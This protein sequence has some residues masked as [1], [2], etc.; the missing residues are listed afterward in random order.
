MKNTIAANI[1]ELH[2]RIAAACEEFD[3]DADDITAVAITKNHPAAVIRTAV[4]SGLVEIGES[5]VLEAK[6][7]IDEVGRIARFHL[8]GHLQTNKVKTAV[9]TFDVIQSVDSLRLAE[10]INREAGQAEL[11]VACLIEVNCSG[12]PQ[13]YGVDPAE[14]ID[15]VGRVAAMEHLDLNGLMTIGPNTD[16]Q[17]AIR[18]AFAHCR[19]LFVQG[20]QLVGRDFDTLSMGMS[21]DFELA[22]AEGSTMIRIGSLL[23]GQR[24]DMP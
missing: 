23:F 19:H 3:R 15:L 17:G 1:M 16:D 13:K 11:T 18:A 9:A 5:R 14:C 4:A 7:K 8:V 6:A 12:E 21:G 22:I 24:P 2:G 20:Q 10:A